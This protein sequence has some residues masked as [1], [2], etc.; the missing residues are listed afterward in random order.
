V[1][2][3]ETNGDIL[4]CLWLKENTIKNIVGKDIS[5]SFERIYLYLVYCNKLSDKYKNEV[6]I[7]ICFSGILLVISNI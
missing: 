5:T 7:F 1:R 4:K 3:V 2:G 6:Y